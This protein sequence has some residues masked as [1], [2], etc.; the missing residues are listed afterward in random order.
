ML[1][2]QKPA[3][4]LG[5]E[6]SARGSLQRFLLICGILSSLWYVIINI[7]VPMHYPGYSMATF[8]ISEL[9]AIDA[10]TRTLWVALVILYPI[11][12]AAFGWGVIKAAN[13]NRFLRVT[14]L[15]IVIYSIFNIYWPPM[16]QRGHEMTLTD[17]L[18]IVWAIITVLFMMI[19]MVCGALAFRGGF[20]FLYLLIYWDTHAFWHSNIIRSSKYRDKWSD[21]L[22]WRLGTYQYR[23]IHAL[24][25]F[26]CNDATQFEK[27]QKMK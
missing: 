24:D 16:H 6:L 4:Q 3:A 11:L 27:K 1:L 25:Y 20:S 19:M 18:H 5:K 10:P 2:Q 13:G 17:K 12:F 9:S 15:L 21:T 14:G 22:D 23:G 8:T 26:I 7:Y